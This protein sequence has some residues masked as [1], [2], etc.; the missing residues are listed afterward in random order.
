MTSKSFCKALFIFKIVLIWKMTALINRTNKFPSVQKCFFNV[1]SIGCLSFS[2][3]NDVCIQFDTRRLFS[4]SSAASGKLLCAHLKGVVYGLLEK[5]CWYLNSTAKQ[6]HQPL[7]T[8]NNKVFHGN[9]AKACLFPIYRARVVFENRTFFSVHKTERKVSG[10]WGDIFWIWQKVI[11]TVSLEA[12][13][14]STCKLHKWWGNL[15]PPAHTHTHT[16]T[17]THL[18]F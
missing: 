8:H 16:H 3:Q 7:Q 13:C 9:A 17:R 14:G 2:V 11:I 4:H 10:P 18:N 15:N 6:I 12:I 1:T 5:A